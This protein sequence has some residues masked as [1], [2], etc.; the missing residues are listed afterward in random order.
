MKKILGKKTTNKAAANDSWRWL[1]ITL[2][3]TWVA[4][5]ITIA[6]FFVNTAIKDAESRFLQYGNAYAEHIYDKAT[7][8]QTILEGFSALF[9]VLGDKDTRE[10]SH[11]ARQVIEHHPH[12]FSLEIVQAVPMD[13][14]AKFMRQQRNAGHANF[15]IRTFGY[16]TDR[17]WHIAKDKPVYYPIV[18]IEPMRPESA[19]VLGLDIGSV[20]FLRP[21]LL[22]SIRKKS[23]ITSSPFQLVQGNRAFVIFMPARSRHTPK[24]AYGAHADS[25]LFVVEMVVDALKMTT[26]DN[27]SVPDDMNILVYHT[28]YQAVDAAG[29]VLHVPQP[30]HSAIEQFL[31]PEFSFEKG[32][33]NSLTL[34]MKKQ[35]GWPD[36]NLPL[37]VMLTL[38]AFI[39]S[40]VLFVY[41]RAHH[42]NSLLEIQGKKQLW[43]LANHDVLT[44]L[45]N[46][47]LFMNRMEQAIARAQR[48]GSNFGLLFLDLN[49]F[50]Q[51]NDT[52]GH[53]AGDYLLKLLAQKLQACIRADDSVARLGGDEFVILL[54]GISDAEAME[55]IALK[56]RDSLFKPVTLNG[57]Q[58][59]IGA[60][61]GKATF[62]LHGRT[63][64]ELLRFADAEMYAEKF[65]ARAP[66]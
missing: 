23:A 4:F 55:G 37:M 44:G 41:L 62:P 54:E 1:Y 7:S 33:G 30:S 18:F 17:K 22:E 31:F 11:Y 16:N 20:A 35:V 25:S 9:S 10:V 15:Q 53:A 64:D 65:P 19:E 14:L 52:Y 45:P 3:M 57:H 58:V 40:A 49:G 60:S 48:Q 26:P 29:Q 27:M 8:N 66:G 51:V 43:F 24:G 13:S 50:K 61:I 36:M 34:L 12:I 59:T 38:G 63:P 42:R 6:S 28:D 56:I 5:C 39:S 2:F 47:N 32:V 46:R 21:A